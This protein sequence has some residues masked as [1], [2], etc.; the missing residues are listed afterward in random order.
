[1]SAGSVF[2]AGFAL[3]E[4]SARGLVLGAGLTGSADDASAVFYNPAGITQLKGIQTM[5]GV[6]AINP[7]LDVVTGSASTGMESN[8][9]YPP[10]A[11]FT[12]QIN[13]RFFWGLGLFSRF[14]LGT[15]FPADWPGRYNSYKAE[16]R[17]LEL[18]PNIACKITDKL[19]IAGGLSVMWFDLQLRQKISPTMFG[20]PAGLG[21]ADSDLTGDSWGW[22]F[23]LALHYKPTDW[24][25]AGIS[26]RSRVSQHVEGD[27]DFTKPAAW[28]LMGPASALLLNDTPGHGNIRLPDMVFAGVNFKPV[29]TLNVG[30]G[31]YWTRWSTYDKLQL[32]YDTPIAPGVGTVTKIKDW[33]D[34]FRYMIG[35]E[36][37]VTP[38]WDLR[39]SY[40]F[41]ES[42][43]PDDHIDYILPDSDR[44][45]FTIG[46]GW[47]SGP[48]TVDLAYMYILFEDRD[49]AARAADG[50]SQGKVEDGYAHLISFSLGYKF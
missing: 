32:T 36:W 49:I 9:F 21:D 25:S 23:N 1:M 8:W 30:G 39:L 24:M 12:Q 13:D 14:G 31:V 19:S 29:K 10:H 27:A 42:P 20:A 11:Y 18:N 48:W 37:N 46:G 15:E 17:T 2:A 7:R 3:Y 38:N 50:V 22:G 47:H 4:G 45:Q 35:V 6:T 5:V 26:Y 44:H 43:V 41:D 33:D 28:G 16:I 40:A 34:V